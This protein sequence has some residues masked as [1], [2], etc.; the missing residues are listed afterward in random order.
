[1]KKEDLGSTS[2]GTITLVMEVI[3]NKVR[4]KCV[5]A[6]R[7]GDNVSY[8]IVWSQKVVKLQCL[9]LFQVRAGIRTFQPKETKLM[10]ENPKF[11]KKV[12][13]IDVFN[14]WNKK[15]CQYLPLTSR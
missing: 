8:L 7:K 13:S 3:F 1:M 2:K 9:F 11:S 5:R 6:C 4:I 10:E 15:A 14:R 12:S